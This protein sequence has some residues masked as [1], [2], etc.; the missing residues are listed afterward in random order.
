MSGVRV[1]L[2]MMIW[3][4]SRFKGTQRTFNIT[5]ITYG[6][7]KVKAG[8]SREVSFDLTALNLKF[9]DHDLAYVCA[10]GDFEIMIGPNSCD[11]RKVTLTLK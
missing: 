8:G 10:P 5:T 1:T 2:L 7:Y 9:Y 3:N 6:L 4:G 11:V